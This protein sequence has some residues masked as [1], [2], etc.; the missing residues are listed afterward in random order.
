M[1]T[2]NSAL[3]CLILLS[4]VESKGQVPVGMQAAN[5]EIIEDPT[6]LSRGTQIDF[7][8]TYLDADTLAAQLNAAKSAD[9]PAKPARTTNNDGSLESVLASYI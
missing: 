9:K 7:S 2:Y 1:R 8:S 4:Q 3:V 6:I 5:Q